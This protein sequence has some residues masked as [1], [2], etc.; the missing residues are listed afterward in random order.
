MNPFAF[1]FEDNVLYSQAFGTWLY[2]QV[3][4]Y[5]LFLGRGMRRGLRVEWRSFSPRFRVAR[6]GH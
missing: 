2:I 6:H 5:A 1:K 4:E 3:G